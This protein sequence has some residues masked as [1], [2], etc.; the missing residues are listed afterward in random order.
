MLSAPRGKGLGGAMGDGSDG[1]SSWYGAGTPMQAPLLN[2]H[3]TR[4]LIVRASSY[5][6]GS[7]LPR[8]KARRQRGETKSGTLSVSGARETKESV[9]GFRHARVRFLT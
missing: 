5:A 3:Y 7:P 8:R 2:L 9:A 6:A 4:Q 1:K